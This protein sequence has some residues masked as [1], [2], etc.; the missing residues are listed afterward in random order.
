MKTPQCSAFVMALALSQALSLTAGV[1]AAR[2]SEESVES[3]DQVSI[4]Q[5]NHEEAIAVL[6]G[7]LKAMSKID[8]GKQSPSPTCE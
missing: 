6:K 5:K 1:S 4:D 7:A 2:A 8:A 3:K